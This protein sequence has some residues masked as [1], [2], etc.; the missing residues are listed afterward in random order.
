MEALGKLTGGIAH[1]FNN[2]LGVITGYTDLLKVTSK[3]E[4]VARYATE[5]RHASDRGAKLT[6]K[7]LAFSS[8]HTGNRQV[9]NINELLRENQHM[10][11]RILK[12][13]VSFAYECEEN[14]W[15]IETDSDE[16]EDTIL[17]MAINAMHAI[18]DSGTVS[19]TTENTHLT[20]EDANS[21]SLTPGEY[22]VLRI[23]DDG[24][25]IPQNIVDQIFDP[26]FTTKGDKGTGLGLSQVYGFMERNKG[27]VTV[28]SK[29]GL[30]TIFSLYF[31]RVFKSTESPLSANTEAEVKDPTT[32]K[33]FTVLAVDDDPAMLSMLSEMLKLNGY[34][35]I[36]TSK[37]AD[38]LQIL[39]ER[40]VDLVVSDVMMPEINGYELADEVSKQ[41]PHVK[42]QLVSGFVDDDQGLRQDHPLSK[43]LIKKPYN[44][45]TLIKTL[46]DLMEQ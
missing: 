5:I 15:S 6:T 9:I 14:L 24:D 17:N 27:G 3:D 16:L 31:P 18:R 39:K 20:M 2:I 1:D 45:E 40:H 26:F 21:L 11:E 30:G 4:K 8:K 28:D 13:K 43:T 35:V 37:P 12:A 32:N 38:A 19:F 46:E 44:S 41:H 22:V 29:V 33:N 34:S 25:G 10:L 7:L 23:A 36:S 42:I